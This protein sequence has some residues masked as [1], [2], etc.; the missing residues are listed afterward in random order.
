[1]NW[2]AFRWATQ[3]AFVLGLLVTSLAGPVVAQESPRLFPPVETAFQASALPQAM[4]CERCVVA[5]QQCFATCFSETEKGLMGAC[6]TACN[7]AAATCTCD[8]TVALRSEELVQRGL[9]TFTESSTCNPVVSCQP[10]YPSC[11]SWSGYSGCG[12]PFC[13]LEEDCPDCSRCEGYEDDFP[14]C[15]CDPG[16]AHHEIFERFRVC[17]NQFGDSCV[18]WQRTIGYLCG[19]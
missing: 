19:C 5:Q 8:G 15:L 9:V 6:L 2:R 4:T 13:D 12:D 17:F 7:N 18:E 10:N 3:S 11:A 1:M 16:P 14:E